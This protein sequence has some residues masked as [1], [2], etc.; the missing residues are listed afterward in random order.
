MCGF[1]YDLK[2]P[3]FSSAQGDKARSIIILV[4]SAHH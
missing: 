1:I 4:A 2:R 3:V